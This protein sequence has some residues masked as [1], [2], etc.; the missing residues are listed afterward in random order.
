MNRCTVT[1]SEDA[2][3][4]FSL[5]V[6]DMAGNHAEYGRTDRFTVDRTAPVISVSFDN[7]SGR[8]RYYNA[9]RTAAITVIDGSFDGDLF[10]AAISASLDGYGINAPRVIG[11]SHSGDRHY[12]SVSFDG[13]GDYSFTL[14]V[15]DL[16]G[17]RAATYRQELFTIDMTKPAVS[18]FGVENGSANRGEAAPGAEYSDLNIGDNVVRLVLSGYRHPEREV[19]GEMETLEHGGRVRLADFAHV[20]TEDD[21]Y[22]LTASVTDLAGNETEEKLV[23]SVNRFGSNYYFSDMTADYLAEYYHQKGSS[24][25]IFE[26]NA[27]DLHDNKVTIYHDGRA[28]MLSEG[29]FKIDDISEKD[30]WKRYRYSM[31]GS[32]FTEEGV[33]EIFVSSVDEA[34]NL[35]DNKLRGVPVGFAIDRTPPGAVITGVEDGKL[36]EEESR[37]ITVVASDN[38]AMGTLRI[39]INGEEKASFDAEE[40]AE[41]EGKL[42]YTLTESGSWQEIT[43]AF[44]DAAGNRG[45]ADSC[46]VLLTTDWAARILHRKGIWLPI[47]IILAAGIWILAAWR[48]KKRE[49]H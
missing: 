24:I 11:W 1:F 12:A 18:F 47:L 6:T 14:D 16:A 4:A 13:D 40:I 26:V 41:A 37:E 48:R 43:L 31:D 27:D 45:T 39:L 36:Y 7:N 34:G 5:G 25:V 22:L 35:Q 15:T 19:T 2:E 28:V 46:R 10:E 44:E 8:G 17:N 49:E 30:D 9:P 32:L 23:F 21:V 33:Y 29:S 3:Y 20:I 38:M 42:P